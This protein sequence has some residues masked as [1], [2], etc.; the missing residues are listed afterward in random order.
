MHIKSFLQSHGLKWNGNQN[1][2]YHRHVSHDLHFTTT[3]YIKSLTLKSISQ[4]ALKIW[5]ISY[6]L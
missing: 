1:G 4:D 6:I 5:I 3:K 2:N